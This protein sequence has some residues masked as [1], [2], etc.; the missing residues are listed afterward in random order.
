MKKYAALSLFFIVFILVYFSLK[1]EIYLLPEATLN[2]PYSAMFEIVD[3]ATNTDH[4]IA[5][6]I[7]ENSGLSVRLVDEWGDYAIISGTPKVKQDI[8]IEVFYVIRGS[9]GFFKDAEQ[10]KFYRIRVRE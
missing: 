6:I 4:F 1:K 7:P 3:S 8:L 2:Q 5:K 10:T 9:P